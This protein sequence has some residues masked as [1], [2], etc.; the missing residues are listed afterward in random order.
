MTWAAVILTG[1][2]ARRL[3]GVD[4]G[5]LVYE[6]HSLLERALDAV[7]AAS[8][9]VVVGPAATTSRPVTF[10]RESPQG[11]GPLAGLAAGVAELR[12]EHDVV[13]VLAVDMPHVDAS[14]VTRLLV[15]ADGVDAA[16]LTDAEGRRQIAGAVRTSLV[17]AARDAAGAPMRRLMEAGRARDVPAIGQEGDDVDTW[18]D[19]SR[20]RGD[21]PPG[22]APPR[23]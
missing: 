11:A 2:R 8:E 6:G 12:G 10:A 18:E 21:P 14:T 17:P 15:A 23:T 20:L 16:W 7:A 13:V 22:V 1:G 9:T 3:D 19:L 5:S 4:K